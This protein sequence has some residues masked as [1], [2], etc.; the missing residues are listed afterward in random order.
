MVLLDRICQ[1]ETSANA[2][3]LRLDFAL[4]WSS[5][6]DG[7]IDLHHCG[8]DHPCFPVN[9]LHFETLLSSVMNRLCC[10]ADMN[11]V[12]YKHVTHFY[13]LSIRGDWIVSS[14]VCVLKRTLQKALCLQR[15][16][17]LI[18]HRTA[19]PNF[20][21]ALFQFCLLLRSFACLYHIPVELDDFK[22]ESC[23]NV[24]Q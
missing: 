5:E 17:M 9:R 14:A 10:V 1:N 6:G 23:T 20:L 8:A 24:K 21:C 16:I 4:I 11:N 19:W 13:R 22:L 2:Y 15:H 3:L 7:G 12:Q 18:A